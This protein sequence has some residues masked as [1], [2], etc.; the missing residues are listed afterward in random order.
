MQIKTFC[1]TIF[2]TLPALFWA[3]ESLS[4]YRRYTEIGPW[5]GF[6]NYSGDVAENRIVLGETKAAYGLVVRHHFARHFAVRLHVLRGDISGDDKNSSEEYFQ[7][8]NFSFFS[9][10]TELGG[11]VEYHLF[12][13]D[14]STGTGVFN[15]NI[16]PYLFAGGAMTFFNP[17]VENELSS[18]TTCT[19][20]EPGQKKRR[21]SFPG[22]L[23]VR[24]DLVEQVSMSVEVG[25]RPLFADDLDGVSLNGNKKANDW[26]V[27]FGGTLSYIFGGGN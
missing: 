22:G 4:G 6:A 17:T 2:L 12:D 9:P 16:T 10:V 3:Q 27:F 24:A 11:L 25:W 14:R 21:L 5:I 23:G 1:L 26:Y 20:P 8:R 19:F 15:K 13:K 18:C 7:K